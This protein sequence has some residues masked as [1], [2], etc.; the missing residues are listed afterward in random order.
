M[1]E[2]E[3]ASQAPTDPPEPTP[4]EEEV[5]A[6]P[7]EPLSCKYESSWSSLSKEV[8]VDKIRG[9][10]YGQAIGDALGN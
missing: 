4:G 7:S 5:S 2:S 10:I 3:C 1:A 6:K 8:I 9:L